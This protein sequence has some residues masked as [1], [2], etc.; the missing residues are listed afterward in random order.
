MIDDIENLVNEIEQYRN[1]STEQNWKFYLE[2]IQN[3]Q[4]ELEDNEIPELLESLCPDCES[5][6]D[7]EEKIGSEMEDLRSRAEKA[8][9]GIRNCV[10]DQCWAKNLLSHDERPAS[11][12]DLD[13]TSP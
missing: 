5:L 3:E 1:A 13:E 10:K 8:M 12:S 9:Q 6:Q 11:C 2:Y 4:N 7:Y